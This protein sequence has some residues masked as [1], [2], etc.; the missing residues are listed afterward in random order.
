MAWPPGGPCSHWT[1]TS[2]QKSG[3]LQQ[4]SDPLGTGGG[5]VGRGSQSPAGRWTVPAPHGDGGGAAVAWP[6]L[7]AAIPASAAAPRAALRQVAN[8]HAP[9]AARR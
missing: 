9:L 4:V 8:V 1:Q 7:N 2:F 5:V 6:Q 3:A